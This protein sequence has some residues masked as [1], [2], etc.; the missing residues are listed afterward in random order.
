MTLGR[1]FFS[2]IDIYRRDSPERFAGGSKSEKYPHGFFGASRGQPVTFSDD[3]AVT[4]G[5]I[6]RLSLGPALVPK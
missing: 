4:V 5:E 2:V 6:L 1:F 3:R